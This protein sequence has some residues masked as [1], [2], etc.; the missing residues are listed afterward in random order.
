MRLTRAR[1]RLSAF[2][3]SAVLASG[4]VL[5]STTGPA[6]AADFG[7]VIPCPSDPIAWR[8]TTIG[9]V[10]VYEGFRYTAVSATPAFN[11]S[12]GRV[13]DNTLDTPI[14][15]TFTSS[16]SR[17]WRVVITTTVGSGTELTKYLQTSVSAQIVQ[18]RTTSLGVNANFTVA[19]HTRVT[20]QYG[21]QAYDVVYDVQTVRAWPAIPN[22]YT[23]CWDQGSQRGTTN[24]PTVI[25]G[26]RFVAG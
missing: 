11:I 7:P 18:E 21:V 16:Q 8:Q 4:L 17:T 10:A 22:G 20:G 26:W 6:H 2:T 9:R 13:V 24:A 15:V 23:K 3:M 14:D 5:V 12:D 19:P 25:E 1:R